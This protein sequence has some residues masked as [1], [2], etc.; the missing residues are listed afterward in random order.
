M[1]HTSHGKIQYLR[2]SA[3]FFVNQE[4]KALASIGIRG[5]DFGNDIDSLYRPFSADNQDHGTEANNA[6]ATNELDRFNC[7]RS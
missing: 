3:F 6:V 5:W 4:F 7:S 2:I 1:M